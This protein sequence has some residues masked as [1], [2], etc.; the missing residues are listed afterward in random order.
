VVGY[1]DRGETNPSDPYPSFSTLLNRPTDLTAGAVGPGSITVTATGTFPHLTS[2]QSGLRFTDSTTDVVSPWLQVASWTET[3]LS[4]NTKYHFIVAARNADG[5]ITNVFTEKDIYS[6]AQV[7]TAPTALLTDDTHARVIVNA[8]G[9]PEIT[10][11]A[12]AFGTQYVQSDGTLGNAAVFRTRD[13]WGGDIGTIVSGLVVGARYDVTVIAANGD[14]VQTAPSIATTA[15]LVPSI[16]LVKTVLSSRSGRSN[17]NTFAAA[18]SALTLLAGGITFVRSRGKRRRRTIALLV[19]ALSIFAL[20]RFAHGQVRIA[21]ETFFPGDT[22]T[23]SIVARN[24][25]AVPAYAVL[26][27]DPLPASLTYVRGSLKIGPTALTDGIDTDA[28]SYDDV[29]HLWRVNMPQLDP[30]AEKTVTFRAVVR[31]GS[32]GEIRNKAAAHFRSTRPVAAAGKIWMAQVEEEFDTESN[33]TVSSIGEEAPSTPPPP[34]AHSPSSTAPAPEPTAP[35][36]E[37]EPQLQPAVPGSEPDIPPGTTPSPGASGVP[38]PLEP[39]QGSVTD[40]TTP[41]F[42]GRAD[43]DALVTVVVDGVV[44]GSTHANSWGDWSFTPDAAAALLPGAHDWYAIANNEATSAQISFTI[45]P[46]PTDTAPAIGPGI[47]SDR[48]PTPL[49]ASPAAGSVITDATPTFSGTAEAGASLT[50][51]VDGSVVAA[52]TAGTDGAW[53]FTSGVPFAPG[54]HAWYVIADGASSST[55]ARF[56]VLAPALTAVTEPMPDQTTTDLTPEFAGIAPPGTQVELV[57]DGERVAHASS[58]ARGVWNATPDAPLEQGD[59]SLFIRVNGSE[60]E[61]LVFGI[62]DE[63]A[64]ALGAATRQPAT[65]PPAPASPVAAVV[66]SAPV[67]R[68][69]RVVR[70]QVLDNPKVEAATNAVVEPVTTVAVVATAAS[71]GGGLG[72]LATYLRFLIT[73]PLALRSRRKARYYGVAF[74]VFTKLPVGLTMVRLVNAET[75]RIVQTRVTGPDGGY[76][77]IVGAGRYKLDI[78]KPGFI[79]PPS[80]KPSG[81]DAGP[82]NLYAGQV[83]EVTGSVIAPNIALEPQVR[84]A[85]PSSLRWARARRIFERVVAIGSTAFAL[86]SLAV[87]VNAWTVANAIVQLI[88]LAAFLRFSHRVKSPTIGSVRTA[89]GK[90]VRAVVRLFN[91]DY[92]KLVESMMTAADGGFAFLVGPSR[93]FVTAEAAGVGTARSSII[94]FTGRTEPGWVNPHLTL[95]AHVVAP[96]AP[97]PTPPSIPPAPRP[98]PVFVPPP[99]SVP[100]PPVIPKPAPPPP[101]PRSVAPTAQPPVAPAA[102][103]TPPPPKRTMD[104]SAP[105]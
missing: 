89:G 97:R 78:S 38:V 10:T 80:A 43:T 35:A 22:L 25:G 69:I 40:D 64:R 73:S 65:Q 24:V 104:H 84:E 55:L 12:I 103:P 2:G 39:G 27:T 51:V 49:V 29:G 1:N 32:T 63:G 67:A 62:G 75:G 52:V 102:P 79:F 98:A 70:T 17:G 90:A 53:R 46:P 66:S 9:N 6:G 16:T 93:F 57:V 56:T 81:S 13:V 72:A 31:R 74:N 8:N 91:A 61:L 82:A 11:Y 3:G 41:T 54:E 60:T 44:L 76:L 34:P 94:D 71:A 18:A 21:N 95:S 87:S 92:N 58:N 101:P 100:P 86:F 37:P 23:Y 19:A 36:P 33:E 77:F 28:G 15:R 47:S 88:M 26:V 85:T 5:V 50:L 48:A 45:T 96:P 14:N 7:P 59:H 83:I 30:G 42:S 68:A 105:L 4:P 20:V 99:R